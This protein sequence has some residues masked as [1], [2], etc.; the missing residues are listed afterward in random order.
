MTKQETALI[1]LQRL[2]TKVIDG[3]AT[4][5]E[6]LALES[7]LQTKPDLHGVFVQIMQSEAALEEIHSQDFVAKNALPA[8]AEME[9]PS[10]MEVL[11]HRLEASGCKSLPAS[12]CLSTD[13]VSRRFRLVLPP[14]RIS[15]PAVTWAVA[16]SVLLMLVG[17]LVWPR[18]HALLAEAENVEW[19]DGSYLEIG[20][21]L[22]GQWTSIDSGSVLL[23]YD[24][25]A[26]IQI[27][28]PARFRVAGS[29][30]CELELGSATA[31]VPPA[32]IGFTVDTPQMLVID[33]GTSFRVDVSETKEASLQVLEGTVDAQSK[34]GGKSHRLTAGKV[35]TTGAEENQSLFLVPDEQLFPETSNRIAFRERHV[36][37]LDMNGFKGDDRCYVFLE[38]FNLPLPHD[39]PINLANSGIYSQF[40]GVLDELEQGTRVDCYLIHSAPRKERHLV[41]GTI[42]FHGEILGILSSS[43]KLNAT[44]SLFGSPWLLRCHHPERGLE[45]SPDENSDRVEISPGRR[46]LRMSLRTES[47]DQMRVLVKAASP[48][49]SL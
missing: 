3:L 18:S 45:N 27:E 43:D 49:K 44:N 10:N 16:A 30:T 22:G 13:S 46:T 34:L 23:S 11:A 26:V 15:R 37:S 24:S 47:I 32:A 36:P 40:D 6:K 28:G 9:Q 31:Y 48:E 29:R 2:T 35:A 14:L 7:L 12:D 5:E 1:Q 41:E 38:R 39:L 25:S 4:E 42:T 20:E 21:R 17:Y 19:A 33:R 8:L